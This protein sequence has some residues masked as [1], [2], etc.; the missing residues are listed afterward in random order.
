ML[1]YHPT[2]K[3]TYKI[4]QEIKENQDGLT[5]E[6][7]SKKYNVSIPTIQKWRKREDFNDAPHGA[8]NPIKSITDIEEYIICEIRKITLLP[9][10]DLL[11]VVNKNHSKCFR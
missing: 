11:D 4:R 7:Q 5:L 1:S 8:K 3:T 2:A 9:L 10:D 6:E